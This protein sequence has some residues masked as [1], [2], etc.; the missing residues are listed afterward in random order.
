M[1]RRSST[2]RS[3]AF[4]KADHRTAFRL[5]EEGKS[6]R[7]IAEQVEAGRAAMGNWVKKWRELGL[8]KPDETEPTVDPETLEI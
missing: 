8:V 7:E 4:E 6:Y 2:R 1:L 3:R 5:L